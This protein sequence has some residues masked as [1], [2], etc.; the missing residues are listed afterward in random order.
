MELN[1]PGPFAI[2]LYIPDPIAKRLKENDTSQSVL[3]DRVPEL[4]FLPPPWWE[5]SH[6]ASLGLVRSS[7]S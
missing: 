5:K 3:L 1:D 7:E 2:A 4:D 6:T